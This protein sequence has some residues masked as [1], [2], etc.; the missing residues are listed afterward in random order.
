MENGSVKIGLRVGQIGRL[1]S[2]ETSTV[3]AGERV[4][5]DAVGALS[6]STVS[7]GLDIEYNVEI[8]NFYVF[9]FQAEGGIRG[10]IVTEVQTCA[11]PI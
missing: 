4:E 1:I 6:R 7:R 9:F 10:L 5:M 3:I 2:I 11:L 8:F